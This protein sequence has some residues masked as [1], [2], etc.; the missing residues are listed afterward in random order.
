MPKKKNLKFYC[1]V[2][3]NYDHPHLNNFCCCLCRNRKHYN[4]HAKTLPSVLH[5]E[6]PS[7]VKTC[8]HCIQQSPFFDASSDDFNEFLYNDK[9]MRWSFN[10]MP[11]LLN[12][13]RFKDICNLSNDMLQAFG[14]V[15]SSYYIATDFD[16][17]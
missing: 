8:F 6:N 10:N 9:D 5:G 3:K 11:N 13:N 14:S 2:C 1:T 17:L 12:C 7:D 4:C 16:K 15:L